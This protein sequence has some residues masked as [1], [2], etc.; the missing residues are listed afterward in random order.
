[1]CL[2]RFD[3]AILLYHYLSTLPTFW[4]AYITFTTQDNIESMGQILFLSVCNVASSFGLL[5]DLQM[6]RFI[7]IDSE[8]FPIQFHFFNAQ[9]LE[10]VP[11]AGTVILLLYKWLLFETHVTS[12]FNKEQAMCQ[13]KENIKH[14]HSFLMRFTVYEPLIYGRLSTLFIWLF[15]PF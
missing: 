10:K 6:K 4:Y 5:E 1:M 2:G 11:L 3:T 12:T 9:T 7:Q 14:K 15:S 8:Y 13:E